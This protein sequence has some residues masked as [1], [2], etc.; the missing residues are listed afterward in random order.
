M[1]TVVGLVLLA[2]GSGGVKPCIAAFGGDQ[3]VLPAQ[4]AQMATFFSLFYFIINIGSLASTFVTPIIR[5]DV[6][7]FGDSDCYPL[8]FGVPG[9]LMVVSISKFSSNYLATFLSRF[10]L[11]LFAVIFVGGK[12][13]YKIIPPSGDMF[14]KIFKCIG[15][16]SEFNFVHSNESFHTETIYNFAE[17]YC[18]EIPRKE[19]KDT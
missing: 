6:Y 7:C 8:A 1:S 12:P 17:C 19:D 10:S 4:A 5:Q 9:V 3:F 2:V 11:C 13:L 16:R 15:V 18:D 14:T